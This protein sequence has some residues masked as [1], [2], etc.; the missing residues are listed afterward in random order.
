M[1]N[2]FLTLSTLAASG[3]G[4]KAQETDLILYGFFPPPVGGEQLTMEVLSLFQFRKGRSGI[5]PSPDTSREGRIAVA[6]NRH[7]FYN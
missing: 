7:C 4:V 5:G 2:S 1:A 6:L 3:D